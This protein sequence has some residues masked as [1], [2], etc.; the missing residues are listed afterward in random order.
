MLKL[1]KK[2]RYFLLC[3]GS[4]TLI[5][6]YNTFLTRVFMYLFCSIIFII[7]AVKN[8]KIIMTMINVLLMIILFYVLFIAQ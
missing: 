7:D 2:S 6:Y 5:T 3:V 8:R 4:I 1:L